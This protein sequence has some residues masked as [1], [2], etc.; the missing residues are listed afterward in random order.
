MPLKYYFASTVH[1]SEGLELNEVVVHCDREFVGGL[2]YVALSR[3]KRPDDI[4]VIGFSKDLVKDRSAQINEI[5]SIPNHGFH[6]DLNCC[7]HTEVLSPD[8]V[9]K[10]SEDIPVFEEDSFNLD[11]DPN[12]FIDQVSDEISDIEVSEDVRDEFGDADIKNLVPLEQL[13]EDIEQCEHELEVPP[14]EFD[15][16][17]FYTKMCDTS[18]MKDSEWSTAKNKVINCILSSLERGKLLV[19]LVWMKIFGLVKSHVATNISDTSFSMQFL[20]QITPKVWFMN[21]QNYYH[22]WLLL[23]L[24][25]K[26]VNLNQLKFESLS[27]SEISFGADVAYK[28]FQELLHTIADMLRLSITETSVKTFQVNE[29]DNTG[30]ARLRYIFGYCIHALLVHYKAYTSANISS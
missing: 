2:L 9:E 15:Y 11:V 3:V 17:N 28:I 27:E 13:L 1:K 6:P 25:N 21:T 19:K 4:Q 5:K 16:A 18:V 7:R 14:Q 22:H 10:L 29:M 20:K 12:Q 26:L 30:K 24:R 23:S 8:E